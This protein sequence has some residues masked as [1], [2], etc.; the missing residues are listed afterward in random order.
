MEKNSAPEISGLGLVETDVAR[1][2]GIGRS[3]IVI[4][5][6]EAL[7]RVG[8]RVDD[9]GGVVNLAGFGADRLCARGLSVG[10]CE[11]KRECERNE[12]SQPN[13]HVERNCITVGCLLVSIGGHPRTVY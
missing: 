7:R 6:E 4:F 11:G 2:V 12:H 8:V 1:I 10:E 5:V 13:N 9:D 3:D